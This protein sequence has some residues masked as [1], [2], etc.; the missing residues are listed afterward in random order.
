MIN[1]PLT[2][3]Y[4]ILL[5]TMS[6]LLA[7]VMPVVVRRRSLH[8]LA[9]AS[10]QTERVNYKSISAAF[11]AQTNNNRNQYYHIEP[12]KSSPPPSLKQQQPLHASNTPITDTSSS[13]TATTTATTTSGAAYYASANQQI[14]ARRNEINKQKRQARQKA[15]D[16][17][18]ERNLMLRNLFIEEKKDSTNYD[19]LSISSSSE[20]ITPP[21]PPMFAVKLVTCPTLRLDLK[22]NG[23]EKRGRMFVE[24]PINFGAV[25]EQ[26]Q[27][28]DASD[29]NND[30]YACLSLKALKQTIHEFFR[31]LKKSTY[32][33]SA[34][35]PILDKDGNVLM[36]QDEEN[37]DQ[38]ND[39]NASLLKLWH[40]ETDEDVRNAFA[41]AERYFQRHQE[42]GEANSSL[43]KRP[44]LVIHVAKDPNAPPPLPTPSYLQDMPD[45]LMSPTMTM[46]SFYAF[47]PNG[48]ISDPE[49]TSDQLKRLW[50]PFR[51]LGRVYVA[52]EGINAQMSVPTNVLTNFLKCCTLSQDE[53]G[54]LS[55]VLGGY[56]E[57]GINIDPIPVEMGE[58]RANPAFKNLHI[59][60]R[61]QIVADGLAK[62]LD[63]QSA[64]YDMPP[65]EWHQ[66][67]KE[68]REAQE[69]G[70]K[71]GRQLPI[72]LD[73]RND[74]ETQ[75]GRF[76]LSEPLDTVNF[77]DSWNVLKER[78]RD[79]PK[80][81][82]IMTYCTGGIRCVKVN[83][84]LTQEMG[85]TNVSRLAGGIISYDRTLNEQAPAEESMFKGV[86]YVFDGRMGRR[87][88]D[89][90]LGTC[91][92]CGRKT[93]LLSNCKNESCHRRMVQ[94]EYCSDSF[95]G[96]C[97]EGCKGRVVNAGMVPKRK[98]ETS[99]VEEKREESGDELYASLDEYSSGHST[100]SPPLFRE[101]ELNT[102]ALLPSG[103]H[104][105]SGSMQGALLKTLASQTSGRILE[106]GTFTGYATACFLEGASIA[107][108]M[109]GRKVSGSRE[110][111]PFVLSLERDRRALAIASEH[112]KVMSELGLG[113][114]AAQEARKLS[115]G[116]I[117]DFEDDSISFTYKKI[118]GCE[119]LR[120]NDA[121]AT[122]E[123][124]ADS[125][126]IL[127]PF[128]IA[129]VDADKNRL[130]EYVDALVRNDRLLKKGG[131]IIVD[132]VLWKG[133]VLNASSDGDSRDSIE[134]TSLITSYK[135]KESLKKSRRARKLA[136][137]MH[138]FNFEVVRDERVEVLMMPIRDGLS[139]IRKR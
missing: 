8:V 123:E 128:D 79:V 132:N 115:Y 112:I 15:L 47:P 9:S 52:N 45:P 91:Y 11:V 62:K 7:S 87:I 81:A 17:D 56:M 70:V 72:V 117:A 64:G 121:L 51:A 36:S 16:K 76:L 5:L 97:S 118:A 108:N 130:M 61:S 73:C 122:V 109:A 83:A 21:P 102:A 74:Y 50:R 104:M 38:N 3:Q 4:L 65:L 137:A 53:G 113:D 71:N 68:A 28:R 98:F 18:R 14:V 86:N 77:R 95:F 46:L 48:G 92:T 37:N 31:R 99:Y 80:D 100:P 44:T 119:L 34:S 24:R 63:W 39:N 19:S 60:V 59:R 85:M 78:L 82:P 116:P 42:E 6:F 55:H 23:R 135:E 133:L 111:G 40:L 120:V 43:L 69:K 139:L 110:D 58:F 129:F 90:Q 93:H 89:D 41:Q 131:L 49:S 126:S 26:Q 32:I 35:L 67:L 94:C 57:N 88:T 138:Q 124:M 107:G 75:V 125:E 27:H 13:K 54:E 20:A 96:A 29:D 25:A 136:M 12:L 105:V 134:Q 10:A 103:A 2:K 66:K 33:L 1:A 127:S 84:Y 114:D 30:D 22:M 101:I 106:I